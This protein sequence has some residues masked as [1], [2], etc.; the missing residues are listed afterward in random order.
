MPKLEHLELWLGTSEYG[1][2]NDPAPLKPLLDGKRFKKLTSL[3]LRN[4]EIADAVARAVAESPLLKRLEVLDLSLGNLTDVGAEALLAS[5]DVRKLKKLDLHHHF[6]TEPFVEE[7]KK[8]PLE[9]DVS[10]PHKPDF[11][12]SNDVTHVSRYNAVSE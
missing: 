10:D 6:L 1:G 2:I 7:L 9:L 12:T 3:G 4:S 8:L 5:P 11:W